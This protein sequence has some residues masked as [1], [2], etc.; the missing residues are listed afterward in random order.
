LGLDGRQRIGK[1]VQFLVNSPVNDLICAFRRRLLSIYETF[2]IF[3]ERFR[4]KPRIVF[5]NTIRAECLTISVSPV[6]GVPG[7]GIQGKTGLALK[8]LVHSIGRLEISAQDLLLV[9]LL[10]QKPQKICCIG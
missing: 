7:A 10:P 4:I 2:F 3:F 8:Y 9:L 5:G 6:F 1:K